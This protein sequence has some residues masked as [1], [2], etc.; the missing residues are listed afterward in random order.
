[1]LSALVADRRTVDHVRDLCAPAAGRWIEA[2]RYGLTDPVFAGIAPAVFDL[3]LRALPDLGVA[4]DLRDEVA[5]VIEG[6]LRH[7]G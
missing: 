7:A 5:G 4:P 1:M 6:R 3:A 2:A